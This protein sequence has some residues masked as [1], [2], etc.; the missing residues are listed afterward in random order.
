MLDT[1][2][3]KINECMEDDTDFSSYFND[4]V[5]AIQDMDIDNEI[6]PIVKIQSTEYLAAELKLQRQIK[7]RRKKY[8]DDM[9]Q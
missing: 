2:R 6:L 1:V 7:R 9:S 3:N 4:Y 8:A 5:M